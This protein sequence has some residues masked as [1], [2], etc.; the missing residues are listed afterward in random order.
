MPKTKKSLP[1]GYKT[2]EA[3]IQE[4]IKASNAALNEA[5]KIADDTGV[6]FNI[7][8]GG[9]RTYVPEKAI[10]LRNELGAD[11]FE[12]LTGNYYVSGR[13]WAGWSSSSDEC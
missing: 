3:E 9:R 10:D 7:T 5:K 4:L 8:M 11:K 12:E 1:E 2:A 13:D 6:P